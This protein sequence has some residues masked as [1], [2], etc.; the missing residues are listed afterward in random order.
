MEYDINSTKQFPVGLQRLMVLDADIE[1]FCDLRKLWQ[2]FQHFSSTQVKIFIDSIPTTPC[3][4]LR[5]WEWVWT[6]P[7]ITSQYRQST[8]K[9]T[10]RHT[11]EN[12]EISVRWVKTSKLHNLENNLQGVNTGVALYSLAGMRASEEY[13]RQ[14]NQDFFW[15]G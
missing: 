9:P 12:Q 6:S 11:S 10:L 13:Q 4:T 15:V 2:H 3:V 14:V 5:C 8:K 7:L 1:V